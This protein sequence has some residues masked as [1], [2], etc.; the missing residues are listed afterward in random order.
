MF[1]P[2]ADRLGIDVVGTTESYD[3]NPRLPTTAVRPG[4]L[5]ELHAVD[6]AKDQPLVTRMQVVQRL[7]TGF[8]PYSQNRPDTTLLVRLSGDNLPEG[9]PEG[10]VVEMAGVAIGSM[11]SHDIVLD[12]TLEVSDALDK[13]PVALDDLNPGSR[14]YRSRLPVHSFRLLRP[15]GDQERLQEIH[16]NQ[17]SSAYESPHLVLRTQLRD[18]VCELLQELDHTGL[19]IYDNRIQ[20]MV[21]SDAVDSMLVVDH[22]SR[23][24]GA[25]SSNIRLYD[26][27][28][29]VLE[30]DIIDHETAAATI[31]IP[32]EQPDDIQLSLLKYEASTRSDSL[33]K[34]RH[35]GLLADDV[36]KP[37]T[38]YMFNDNE[39]TD[40]TVTSRITGW[41]AREFGVVDGPGPSLE[42]MRYPSGETGFSMYPNEGNVVNPLIDTAASRGQTD[43]T[44]FV[45]DMGEHTYD[46]PSHE[47]MLRQAIEQLDDAVWWLRMDHEARRELLIRTDVL[48]GTIQ[49][50]TR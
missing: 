47:Q 19:S 10:R 45:I 48:Q 34:I 44:G 32:A 46:I 33:H 18:K 24:D 3:V 50:L 14:N 22:H 9:V 25:S 31:C 39:L 26:K 11:L 28:S 16:L 36:G 35:S 2:E 13:S 29:G 38:T 21:I 30:V 49:Q 15:Q 42:T 17:L 20:G 6:P 5:I 40:G 1:D 12:G 37:L 43:A 8:H 23:V 41:S 4:D 27:R 7:M